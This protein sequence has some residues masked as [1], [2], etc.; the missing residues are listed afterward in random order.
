M[1]KPIPFLE[2]ASQHRELQDELLW[3]FTDILKKG[4][5]SAGEEVNAF[6]MNVQHL[7]NLPS[8]IA[9]SN[10]T[11]ALE[12]AL[13]ALDIGPGDEVVVP[14][15]TWVSTAE[16]V[17]NVGA[18]PVFCDVEEDGLISFDH[19]G[20]L[21][22]S[23]TKAVI[24]VHLYGKMVDMK[25]LMTLAER[26][27]LKVIEDAAQAFGA[28][29]HGISAGAYGNVGCFS[30]Y[31][32]KNI[33]ALGEAG[34]VVT[35]D[36]K[37]EEKIRLILNH[38]QPERN[39]HRLAGRNSKIDTLQAGFLN[40]KLGY[41]K[42]WTQWRRKLAAVY[43]NEL[44]GIKELILPEGILA[45]NHNAHLFTVRLKERD[46]LKTFLQENGIGTLIHYPVQLSETEAFDQP[47]FTPMAKQISQSTLSL[48]L[49][50]YLGEDE[51]MRVCETIKVFFGKGV[52]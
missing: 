43:L 50:P 22:G 4:V 38:G 41:Y 17:V 6:E 23:K 27:R 45:E 18:M 30:F 1:K 47:S 48:P 21:I 39:V 33:G 52:R 2:L 49:H 19:I 51:A 29:Q 31:P 42:Q 10:G 7:L 36:R 16:A 14:G 40:V 9:C 26:H 46:A 20:K 34:L 8:T 44:T 11:D 5:F 37:L 25:A 28:F 35:H 13:R 3:K 24:P 15:L 12:L 32:T